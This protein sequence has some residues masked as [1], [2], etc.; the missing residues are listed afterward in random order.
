MVLNDGASIH[1]RCSGEGHGGAGWKC[2]LY[3]VMVCKDGGNGVGTCL[4]FWL[5]KSDL[6]QLAEIFTTLKDP[7]LRDD[8]TE[9]I[10]SIKNEIDE[11][12]NTIRELG[13]VNV[14]DIGKKYE[15]LAKEVGRIEKDLGLLDSKIM[16]MKARIDILARRITN[17]ERR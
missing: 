15:Q 14:E 3:H 4:S 13:G 11:I 16:E 9:Q 12:W 6:E 1:V 5:G 17:L 2:I 10:Q 7:R 8:L